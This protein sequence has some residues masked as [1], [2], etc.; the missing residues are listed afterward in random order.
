MPQK[1]V[2]YGA[3]VLC[4]RGPLRTLNQKILCLCWWPS[5][6]P[7]S[8]SHG[9][10]SCPCRRLLLSSFLFMTGGRNTLRDM[11]WVHTVRGGFVR[12]AEPCVEPE[13]WALAGP[14]WDGSTCPGIRGE[15]LSR[16]F[17]SEEG[18][19]PR[20]ASSYWVT[21]ESQWLTHW[22]PECQPCGGD[23]GESFSSGQFRTPALWTFVGTDWT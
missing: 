16:P 11:W 21:V 18:L 5:S 1:C 8:C 20:I 17:L 13:H 19:Q 14:V 15:A 23:S 3:S 22:A 2:I 10:R 4:W 9:G 12:R 7:F 6:S